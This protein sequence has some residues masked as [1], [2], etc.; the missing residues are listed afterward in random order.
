MFVFWFAHTMGYP[1]TVTQRI[2]MRSLALGQ[3][4]ARRRSTG[5][6]AVGA[7]QR[8]CLGRGHRPG[9]SGICSRRPHGSD[10]LRAGRRVGLSRRA[11]GLCSSTD[12]LLYKSL[13]IAL[14][15]SASI[16]SFLVVGLTMV[17]ALQILLITGGLLGVIPLSGVVSPFLSYGRTSMVANFALFGIV[18][19]VSTKA[20]GNQIG[21]LRT[22]GRLARL[23]AGHR[24][25]GLDGAG[26][27]ICK[28]P[29]ADDIAARPALVV[30]A[31]GPRQYE[32]N[33][34]LTQLARE[35]P[36]GEITDRNGLPLASSDWAKVEA[37][38]KDYA[39]LRSNPRRPRPASAALLSVRSQ[40]VLLTGRR[41]HAPQAGRRRTPP[42][43][44]ALHASAC[45]VSMI[46]RNSK[47][48][49]TR[50]PARPS[51]A[52]ATTIATWCRCCA[53]RTSPTIPLV[54]EIMDRNRNVRMSIDAR[55]QMRA[56][57]I[58]EAHLHQLRERQG[59][60]RSAGSRYRRYVGRRELSVA[61]AF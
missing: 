17:T 24:L 56:S 40:D 37:H 36:K 2:A 22:P 23:P 33:P 10:C 35:L 31:S 44:S 25:S 60:A 39:S 15:A 13:R 61:R 55:L 49:R 27:D 18:L 58:L 48:P 46:T 11:R 54:K 42:S 4:R 12:F 43:R 21:A 8:R 50:P 16:R 28:F 29:Q 47:S 26:G 53:I 9:Q 7:R 32:Y 45:K 57:A 19:A 5:A 20:R 59:L 3:S 30:Q 41:D 1:Q 34:R 14:N 51:A 38:R 6:L 52:C